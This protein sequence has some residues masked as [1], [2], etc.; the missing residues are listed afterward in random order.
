[1]DRLDKM[2]E[3]KDNLHEALRSEMSK[4]KTEAESRFADARLHE[5]LEREKLENQVKKLEEEMKME[6]G[7]RVAE[8]EVHK[9]KA[10]D[11][12]NR[13]KILKDES[14][15]QVA[16]RDQ[17][18]RYMQIKEDRF[19]HS[20]KIMIVSNKPSPYLSTVSSRSRKI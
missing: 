8:L 13:V 17:S 4:L 18:K 6:D 3:Y 19:K 1:M 12:V 20:R 15:K 10:E 16:F 9:T 7:A 14:A 2:I 11:L 5:T